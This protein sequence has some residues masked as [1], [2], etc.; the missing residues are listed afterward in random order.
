M[1][2]VARGRRVLLV[3]DEEDLRNLVGSIVS[4]L[5]YEVDTARDG[6]AAIERIEEDPP[7]LVLLDLVLPGLDG[8]SVLR[9][10]WRDL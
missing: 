5:G 3:D 7:D 4:D 2:E 9:Y 1:A 10:L 8:I 6:L